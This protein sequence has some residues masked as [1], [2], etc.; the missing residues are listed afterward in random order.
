MCRR[1]TGFP[2][3]GRNSHEKETRKTTVE[4]TVCR[5]LEFLVGFDDHLRAPLVALLGLGYVGY[6]C[7]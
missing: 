2:P 3:L 1:S 6:V 4:A 5:K 7:Y